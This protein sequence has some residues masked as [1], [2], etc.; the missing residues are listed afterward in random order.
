MLGLEFG[1]KVYELIQGSFD[2]LPVA[3]LINE[4][5]LCVHGGIGDGL[6]KLDDLR[7]IPKPLTAD[8]MSPP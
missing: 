2:R 4:K 7:T 8:Y 3:C 1:P 6:W 5:I